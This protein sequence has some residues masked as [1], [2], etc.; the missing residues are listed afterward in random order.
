MGKL[1]NQSLIAKELNLAPGT[2][3]RALRQSPGIHPETRERVQQYA[4]KLG[5]TIRSRGR[6]IA[7]ADGH[8]LGVLVQTPES[9]WIQPHHLV[10]LSEAAARMNATLIVHYVGFR[11][12]ANVLNAN[13]QPIAMRDGRVKGVCLI[14]RWPQEVVEKLTRHY[15][16]V[17]IVNFFPSVNVDL[18]DIDHRGGMNQLFEHLYAF[19]HRKIGFFGLTGSF[20]WSR[21]RFAGYVDALMRH[22]LSYNSQ[23]VIPLQP[24]SYEER[25]MPE[26]AVQEAIRLV[27]QQG[28]RAWMGTNEWAGHALV[29]GFMKAGLKVPEDV[30]VTGFDYTEAIPK[31]AMQLTSVGVSLSLIGEVTIRTLRQRLANP[32]E[33]RQSILFSCDM[34]A[35][36]STGPLQGSASG[37]RGAT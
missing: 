37:S 16:C 2:V 9:T 14:H 20:S 24:E 11:D 15:A 10:G 19:G 17:S 18:I 36:Q 27:Q 3:S 12:C 29:N 26:S 25:Y 33:P 28:V 13:N 4:K 34:I 23:W 5:Y 32:D 22:G 21:A 31:A 7:D 30:S 35:G 1:P 8:Y 6:A